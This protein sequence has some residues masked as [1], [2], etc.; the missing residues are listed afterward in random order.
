MSLLKYLAL[1]PIESNDDGPI[2]ELDQYEHD[3][4]IDLSSDEDGEELIEEWQ[5]IAD[6]MHNKHNR[7]NNESDY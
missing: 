7:D 6:D 4:Q 3:E 5:A 1:Q 2:S